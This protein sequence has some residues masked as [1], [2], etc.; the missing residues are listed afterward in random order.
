M[1]QKKITIVIVDDHELTRIGIRKILEQADDMQIVGE[2]CNGD[3]GLDMVQRLRPDALLLD[4]QMPGMPARE[5]ERW[6]RTHY[7]EVVTLVLTGHDRD[8]YLAEFLQ[9]GAAGYLDKNLQASHLVSAIRRAV[10]GESLFTAKQIE[11]AYKWEAGV[12]EKWQSLSEREKEITRRLVKCEQDKDIA[13]ALDIT[14]RTVLFHVESILT[15]LGVKNRQEII[16]WMM[17][18]GLEGEG[19]TRT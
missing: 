12:R 17:E 11:R 3:E 5:I 15:K 1:E 13:A 19:I 9:I 4:I 8:A 6:V 10:K 7:P 14:R 2:A 18:S 16:T